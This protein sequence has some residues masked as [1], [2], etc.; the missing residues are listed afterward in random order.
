MDSISNNKTS[1]IRKTIHLIRHGQTD[2]NLRNIIQGSGVNSDLNATGIQQA[3]LFFENYGHLNYNHIYTSQLNRAIQSVQLFIDKPLPHTKLEGLN[4]INWGIMEG[5]ESTPERHKEYERIIAEWTNGN[6]NIAIEGGET[7]EVLY[8]RQKVALHH[9]LEQPLEEELI[10]IC[11]H[12]RAMRSFLCLLTGISLSEMEK[13]PHHNLCLY[14][15]SYNGKTFD[16]IIE[17]DIRHLG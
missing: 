17:N 13:W 12:G 4:E 14:E 8:Q 7:P 5:K 16:L 11:M 2:F 15:L 9:I 3:Q 6:L 1:K 10:L